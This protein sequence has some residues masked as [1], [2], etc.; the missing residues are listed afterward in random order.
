MGG[1]CITKWPDPGGTLVLTDTVAVGL[2]GQTARS[3]VCSDCGGACLCEKFGA[4]CNWFVAGSNEPGISFEDD[5]RDVLNLVSSAYYCCTGKCPGGVEETRIRGYTYSY[6]CSPPFVPTGLL[7]SW[8]QSRCPSL[9]FPP[10]SSYLRADCFAC[11]LAPPYSVEA[12]PYS[13]E[14]PSSE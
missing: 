2:A 11:K 1:N 6:G 12:P 9:V 5:S 14:T 3:V 4:G 8:L 7:N 13:T 10:P